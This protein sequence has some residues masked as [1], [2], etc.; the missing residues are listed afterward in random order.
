MRFRFD[1]RNKNITVIPLRVCF[2]FS[3]SWRQPSK[4]SSCITIKV[5]HK[6]F[7]SRS[8]ASLFVSSIGPKAPANRNNSPPLPCLLR[9]VWHTSQLVQIPACIVLDW[10]RPN[11]CIAIRPPATALLSMN[12]SKQEIKYRFISFPPGCDSRFTVLRER[13]NAITW[14]PR[15]RCPKTSLCVPSS[16]KW[17]S[18]CTGENP[19]IYSQPAQLRKENSKGGFFPYV[20]ALVTSFS[21]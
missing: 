14:R 2:I 13:D 9:Q 11:M 7:M 3:L 5:L 17:K 10:A 19:I 15:Q 12:V 6:H 20:A 8:T 21:I 16:M 18:F 4:L 1:L